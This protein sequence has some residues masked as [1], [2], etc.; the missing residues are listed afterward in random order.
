M[1]CY[2]GLAALVFS[3]ILVFGF[4]PI[5]TNAGHESLYENMSNKYPI[6]NSIPSN[7]LIPYSISV[8]LPYGENVS[9]SIRYAYDNGTGITGAT[10]A[11]NWTDGYSVMELGSGDYEIT[12]FSSVLPIDNYIARVTV[13]SNQCDIYVEVRSHL[14]EFILQRPV[15]PTYYFDEMEIEVLYR[16]LDLSKGIEN[17]STTGYNVQ[18]RV[19]STLQ[20][21]LIYSTENGTNPGEYTIRLAASQWGSTGEKDLT[22]FVNW[23][24]PTAI[25]QNQSITLDVQILPHQTLLTTP[26]Y[27]EFVIPYGFQRTVTLHY[28]DINGTGL[29][30]ATII[31]SNWTGL[32]N[33][34]YDLGNGYYTVTLTADSI[35]LGIHNVEFSASRFSYETSTVTLAVHVNADPPIL[36]TLQDRYSSQGDTE[37]LTWS[38]TGTY[39]MNYTILQNGVQI[40]SGFWNSS[41][42]SLSIEQTFLSA[43]VFTYYIN[44]ANPYGSATD[45][46]SIYVY[47]SS[48]SNHDIIS[49][50]SDG[51][52]V[53]Q[54][55]PG[56]GT[57]VDPFVISGLR[58]D[59][60]THCISI[61][62]TIAYFVVFDCIL[63]G[64][65][66]GDRGISL[67]D[68]ENGVIRNCTIVFKG[69]ALYINNQN[70]NIKI[71]DIVI[72]TVNSGIILYGS[73][74]ISIVNCT[75]HQSDNY[76][77]TASY[78]ENIVIENCTFYSVPY[79]VSLGSSYGCEI[80][81]NVFD[82]SGIMMQ[83]SDIQHY[84]GNSIIG[85]TLDGKP[86]IVFENQI[87]F[88]LSVLGYGEIIFVNCSN[89]EVTDGYF[90]KGWVTIHVAFCHNATIS[91]VVAE[92]IVGHAVLIDHSMNFTITDSDISTY[93]TYGIY[94][95]NSSNGTV[96]DCSFDTGYIGLCL[97]SC[98]NIDIM[99]NEF[100][101]Y[102]YFYM[103]NSENIA[104][105]SNTFSVQ[106]YGIHIS[107]SDFNEIRNNTI[108]AGDIGLYLEYS[109]NNTIIEND[110]FS[111][112][113]GIYLKSNSIM[114]KVY[115]NRFWDNSIYNAVDDTT[116]NYWDN[117]SVGNYW[118]DYHGLTPS[119]IISGSAGA[120]DQFPGH[121]AEVGAPEIFGLLF[122][123]FNFT[124]TG[125]SIAWTIFG[126]GDGYEIYQNGSLEYIDTW[127]NGVSIFFS[128]DGLDPGLYFFTIYAWDSLSRH[129]IH[130]VWVNV[131]N[132][133]TARS[134]I[135]ITTDDDFVTQGFPGY[136]TLENPYIIELWNITGNPAILI[137]DTTNYFVVQYCILYGNIEFHNTTNG[138]IFNCSIFGDSPT[139]GIYDS[140]SCEI[141]ENH[142]ES[143]D[144]GIWL[145]RSSL[146]E[147]YN[148]TI[149]G[150]LGPG[151]NISDS[152]TCFIF[153]NIVIN[154]AEG[155]Y[156]LGSTNIEI[157]HHAFIGIQY[158]V[159]I[160]DGTSIQIYDLEIDTTDHGI[161]IEDSHFCTITR[162]EITSGDSGVY[163]YLSDNIEVYNC[164]ITDCYTRSISIYE[165]TFCILHDIV[166]VGNGMIFSSLSSFCNVTD[167]EF[168]NGTYGI[169]LFEAHSC[170]L[171]NNI[172][173]GSSATGIGLE[174]ASTITIDNNRILS[175]A[176]GIISWTGSNLIIMNN[177]IEYTTNHGCRLYS[178]NNLLTNNTILYGAVGIQLY[179][180]GSTLYLNKIGWNSLSNAIDDG[181]SNSWYTEPQMGN[182]WDDYHG[183][184]WYYQIPGTAGSIDYYPRH[185]APLGSPSI[186]G[187]SDS[188]IEYLSTGNYLSWA[189][190]DS[191][192][193]SYEVYLDGVL[194]DSGP[195]DGTPVDVLID[196]TLHPGIYLYSMIM[197]DDFGNHDIWTV[198]VTIYNPYVPNP[199]IVILSDQD[200]IDQGWPGS[201]LPGDPYVID[202][203]NITSSGNGIS[204]SNTR[205]YFEIRKCV[206][207]GTTY[208][209]A[210]GIQLI[211]VTNGVI[212]DCYLQWRW[213]A[214]DIHNC[215]KIDIFDNSFFET[216]NCL[217]AE[218]SQY[219][220]FFH[221]TMVSAE[222]SAIYLHTVSYCI[223][224]SNYLSQGESGISAWYTS[225]SNITNNRF[226]GTYGVYLTN[227]NNC[228]ILNNS[229][230]AA[231]FGIYITSSEGMTIVNNVLTATQNGIVL[232]YLY[233]SEIRNNTCIASGVI[234]SCLSI[235]HS[236]YNNLENN[237]LSG[238]SYGL[239][240]FNSSSNT[241]K[242]NTII[243]NDY[244]LY[245]EESHM[246][247]IRWNMFVSNSINNVYDQ[248]DTNTW[249]YNYYSDYSGVDSNGDGIGDT[250]YT[251]SGIGDTDPYPV[252]DRFL[253]DA[254]LIYDSITIT[255]NADF[256]SQDWP[257]NG[258]Q[259]NPYLIQRISVVGGNPSIFISD[260]DV[261]LVIS[262]CIIANGIH[263][264]RVSNAFIE[265]NSITG[266]NNGLEIWDSL[267]CDVRN[268][269]I[270]SSWSGIEQL[271]SSY[272]NISFNQISNGFHLIWVFDSNYTN[273]FGHSMSFT[274]TGI[275]IGNS[276]TVSVFNNYI[277]DCAWGMII[278]QSSF[279]NIIHNTLINN[280]E[281]GL[282]IR[283]SSNSTIAYNFFDWNALDTGVEPEANLRILSCHDLVFHNNSMT[284]SDRYGITVD[285]G[286]SNL[287]FYLN[288]IGWNQYGNALDNGALNHWDNGTIGNR[289]DDYFG[290]GVYNVPGTAGSIDNYPTTLL[291][292]HIPTITSPGDLATEVGQGVWLN[293]TVTDYYPGSYLLYLGSDIIDSGILDIG[294][295]TYVQFYSTI[296]T[297]DTFEY[298]LIIMQDD[299]INQT[300]IVTITVTPD[301]IVPVID[302]PPDVQYI[303]NSTGY[304]I[305]WTAFDFNPNYYEIFRDGLMVSSGFW[306]SSGEVIQIVVDGLPIGVYIYWLT[307]S[308]INW[309]NAT[310]YVNVTV[311]HSLPPMVNHPADIYYY[312]G[313]WGYTITW[314]TYD[315]NPTIYVID[316]DGVAPVFP[317]VY[318]DWNISIDVSGLE[319]GVH[320]AT[321]YLYDADGQM[322]WD[323]VQ[324]F[325]LED[326]TPPSISSPPDV[327]FSEGEEGHIISWTVSD[328]NPCYYALFKNGDYYLVG[329]W[330]S[331]MTHILVSLDG[332]AV[333]QYN[334]T[335]LISDSIFNVTD[336]VIVIVVQSSVEIDSPADILY[337]AGTIGHEI[338]WTLV[339]GDPTMIRIYRNDSLIINS[340]WH[341]LNYT[342]NVDHLGLGIHNFTIMVWDAQGRYDSDIVWVI[343]IESSITTIIP[344][345]NSTNTTDTIT[346]IFDWTSVLSLVISIGSIGIIVIV[347][348]IIF[349]SRNATDY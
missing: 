261:Y 207:Y 319:I 119:Y 187:P 35:D 288:D 38:S 193:N 58:I 74:N 172:I 160:L 171:V 75:I 32:I 79:S 340:L 99:L 346:E 283:W 49:I 170:Y 103:S 176:S 238:Y 67:E 226:V 6:K 50:S 189:A 274:E 213:P 239:K 51:D 140:E 331:S 263:L 269:T 272:C 321:I 260:T 64:N 9:F 204:I 131:T 212:V 192:P 338:T 262:D 60:D 48:H 28:T 33:S 150:D 17:G 275:Y 299:C 136:G 107:Q 26:P 24:G 279:I 113:I 209:S 201:G 151:M 3:L 210:N 155:I 235:S 190:T 86:I 168:Y 313:D 52:F 45:M 225:Y 206:I 330:N 162:C 122:L 116:N 276:N 317:W 30:G 242:F 197:Y 118:D 134:P 280:R 105:V 43:G 214:I 202:F 236:E 100:N 142:I 72:D 180:T 194:I 63:E 179:S 297:T 11:C 191:E 341:G 34:V 39:P 252:I 138:R 294:G 129:N 31:V 104:I 211:N 132:P 320:N 188:M 332:L 218:E 348:V 224:D 195:W 229:I 196:E 185:F 1:L 248:W 110:F 124:S 92:D 161:Y 21:N 141:F 83:G 69:I 182:S 90:E 53:S 347:V 55:W 215:S 117:G 234:G 85:N 304:A 19:E 23:T 22:I 61:T 343:V 71:I 57:I 81:N 167:S 267:F 256:I 158:G 336:T 307:V 273:I 46:V 186:L 82:E 253:Q 219:I 271:R 166:V 144:A 156:L 254:Y 15:E 94:I 37:T 76:G 102:G 89:F 325:V 228:S 249:E 300:D 221:N 328:N 231:N 77:V 163:I 245:V 25:Y 123:E 177:Y 302:S 88:S 145:I 246:C 8:N 36:N 10:V 334:F 264:E 44:V 286:S 130:I 247:E 337:E 127:T 183:L 251:I 227:S 16:D 20:S 91:N 329:A 323:T 27:G 266:S 153:N 278:H 112:E 143:D 97:V 98:Y 126:S 159:Y 291:K 281:N 87:D 233:L 68:V 309:N 285:S 316:L 101:N 65:H 311:L 292:I 244:G 306:N 241:L 243:S 344:I 54:G 308:D 12:L 217:R 270:S 293:W 56:S 289:W 96:S 173:F 95:R 339:R 205:K 78:C 148:N 125:N 18:I 237:T 14:T 175:C 255:S 147:V 40:A 220:R 121:F 115:L 200:F 62:N 322:V 314:D 301:T 139:V 298:I 268:N 326:T 164:T 240:M 73:T 258:T 114:N 250:P 257:G 29:S 135:I 349:R 128:L 178:S 184:T 152:D 2:T 222:N 111:C 137:S 282:E 295:T 333:G 203:L 66:G 345:T 208:P 93:R 312:Y 108:Q 277:H 327:E 120:M 154:K 287:I 303:V 305:S 47:F 232:S 265:F 181:S 335:L 157:H 342:L 70:A 84:L 230:P 296:F 149:I 310:D 284:Y 165:S 80:I 318:G 198:N 109:E 169:E 199:A 315:D 290:V 259:T 59:N 106:Y 4:V 146:C 324:I 133:W 7:T 13:G 216:E 5:N 42:E 223:I 174:Q 41:S